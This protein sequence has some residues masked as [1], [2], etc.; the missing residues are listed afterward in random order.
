M[1]THH[2]ETVNTFRNVLLDS[3]KE[4]FVGKDDIVELLGV[5]LIAREN[6]FL[7]GPPGTAKSA[8]VHAI[9]K[10]L[11][12]R[13][14]D[15]LLTR[16]TE[17]NEL[18]G[19]FD[20]AK[21]KDGDLV[22]NTQG[23]LPEAD[24]VFLDELFNANSAILNNLLM[25]LNEKIFRRGK[26]THHLPALCFVG[27]SNNLPEDKALD[28]LFDRFLL[29]VN[30]GYVED[31]QLRSVLTKGWQQEQQVINEAIVTAEQIRDLQ[32][33]I[34]SVDL[35][36]ST[37]LYLELI[38]KLRNAGIELSDRRAVRLQRVIASSA[39]L[40]GRLV[41]KPTDLWV[42]CHIWSREE[43]IEVLQSIVSSTLER[44]DAEPDDHPASKVTSLPNPEV[45][46]A[47]VQALA[48]ELNEEVS[49][50]RGSTIPDEIRMI[51][52]RVEWLPEGEG[53][54]E[55]NRQLGELWAVLQ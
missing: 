46:A 25:A 18:F 12:G 13:S 10:R 33:L 5:S 30:C 22:T 50:S 54:V 36:S 43:Q 38:H 9:A 7:Y 45:L 27:A 8:L 49:E 39:I 37:E 26:E 15:Y 55:L 44:F 42:L 41:S 29:R 23:M 34:P 31:D 16:F 51:A 21:L 3:I 28:A 6:L 2:L 35:S 53:K 4:Q 40:S 20:I 24:L 1:N 48:K 47:Q 19:P 32:S 52:S 17:P 11:K 14:F